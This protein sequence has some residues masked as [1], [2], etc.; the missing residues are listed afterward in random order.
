MVVLHMASG[1]QGQ[2]RDPNHTPPAP[3]AQQAPP[4]QQTALE[5]FP[6]LEEFRGT[7]YTI[8]VELSATQV[9]IAALSMDIEPNWQGAT[10]IE[11]TCFYRMGFLEWDFDPHGIVDQDHITIVIDSIEQFLSETHLSR[12]SIIGIGVVTITSYIRDQG[13]PTQ[14][15]GNTIDTN[16]D[17]L[18]NSLQRAFNV[19]IVGSNRSQRAAMTEYKYGIGQHIAAKDFLLYIH[20]SRNI[21]SGAIFNGRFDEK[22]RFA[23]GIAHTELHKDELER[24][25]R[26]VFMAPTFPLPDYL[27]SSRCDICQKELCLYM[28]TSGQSIANHM[29]KLIDQGKPTQVI[30]IMQE[31]EENNASL[32]YD[33]GGKAPVNREG[34][35]IHLID[36]RA[37]F[38][39]ANRGNDPIAREFV[40][41]AGVALGLAVAGIVNNG[42]VPDVVVLGGIGAIKGAGDT[43]R[44]V[45][46]AQ[47]TVAIMGIKGRDDTFLPVRP[48]DFPG[49]T[50]LIGAAI[51]ARPNADQ[52]SPDP[53][54]PMP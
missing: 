1:R 23:R 2:T 39:A 48:T 51:S 15:L 10:D 46:M 38:E 49:F 44:L 35:P 54:Q 11:K 13:D 7:R 18:K 41:I 20:V 29:A 4:A 40:D 45:E 21:A 50:A 9:R 12:Q 26:S 30:H 43:S 33:R 31:R 36:A 5:W 24:L 22:G 8:G 3:Q 47:K 16:M 6:G 42:I 52:L 14:Q 53:A 19:R 32:V 34:L 28:V 25:C 17:A 37:V 27:N